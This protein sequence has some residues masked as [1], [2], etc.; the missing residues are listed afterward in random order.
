MKHVSDDEA[1]ELRGQLA[2]ARMVGDERTV[3]LCVR[4][5]SG[6][7]VKAAAQARI[8]CRQIWAAQA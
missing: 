5:L 2:V 3:D 8:W 7:D 6:L 1:H 4:A